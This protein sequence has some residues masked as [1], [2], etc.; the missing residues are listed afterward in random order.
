MMAVLVLFVLGVILNVSGSKA[1]GWACIGLA[2]VVG[3]LE[4]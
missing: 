1:W 4:L 2:A 3:F